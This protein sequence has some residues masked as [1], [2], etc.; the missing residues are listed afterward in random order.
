MNCLLL[1]PPEKPHKS[2]DKADVRLEEGNEET[3]REQSDAVY[4]KL[5]L[6]KHVMERRRQ[7]AEAGV[8]IWTR[9]V[10]FDTGNFFT[11]FTLKSL[12]FIH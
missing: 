8:S 3:R 9:R 12:N 1:A 5:A 6:G 4:Q 7:L 10:D 2:W 11:G